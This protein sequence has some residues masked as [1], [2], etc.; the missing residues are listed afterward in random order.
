MKSRQLNKYI[1]LIDPLKS[2]NEF[3]NHKPHK[4]NFNDVEKKY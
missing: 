2:K 3:K 4:L 1:S